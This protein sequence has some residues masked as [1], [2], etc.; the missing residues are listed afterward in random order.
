MS[1]EDRIRQAILT[2]LETDMQRALYGSLTTTTVEPEKPLDFNKMLRECE[3]VVRAAR[4]EQIVFRADFSHVGPMLKIET[5]ND[6]SVIELSFF[7]AQQVHS[8]WPLRL[9]KVLDRFA[10]EFVPAT[11]FD[12]FV[13]AILPVPPFDVNE[14]TDG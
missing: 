13:P 10:A 6:G 9:H 4:R 11:P 3:R 14:E 7:Q 1:P 5:P 8:Q 2:R 12:R